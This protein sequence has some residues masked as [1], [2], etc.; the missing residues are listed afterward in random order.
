MSEAGATARRLLVG[1]ARAVEQI[2]CPVP[3][4]ADMDGFAVVKANR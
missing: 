4:A 2:T 1:V 3:M